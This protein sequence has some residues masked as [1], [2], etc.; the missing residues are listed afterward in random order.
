MDGFPSGQRGQTVNLLTTSTMVRI[1]LHPFCVLNI[2]IRA[3]NSSMTRD[4]AVWKLVGLI[5]RRSQVQILFPLLKRRCS[6]FCII[7]QNRLCA[8]GL[9]QNRRCAFVNYTKPPLRFC[10]SHKTAHLEPNGSR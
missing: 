4:R 8:F 6:A 1:H 10:K 3:Y 2:M 7:T 9:T 5:T